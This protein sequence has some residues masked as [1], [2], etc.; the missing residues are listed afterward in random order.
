MNI[1]AQTTLV[2]Y[3]MGLEEKEVVLPMVEERNEFMLMDSKMVMG[4]S[5]DGKTSIYKGRES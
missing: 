3:V 5:T 4:N 2:D 1:G